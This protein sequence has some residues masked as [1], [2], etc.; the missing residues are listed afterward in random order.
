MSY[1]S[2]QHINNTEKLR[3]KIFFFGPNKCKKTEGP[4]KQQF[5]NIEYALSSVRASYMSYI[6]MVNRPNN[7]LP[8]NKQF[9]LFKQVKPQIL[10]FLSSD[11]ECV[12]LKPLLKELAFIH[13]VAS[14]N[15]NLM[16]LNITNFNK[17]NVYFQ[18]D[19]VHN[20]FI[21]LQVRRKPFSSP[22]LYEINLFFLKRLKILL[23]DVYI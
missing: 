7:F 18:L 5:G 23:N 9:R 20:Y 15:M 22:V 2:K 16:E 6:K 19:A 17:F 13:S 8:I 11:E 21:V 10:K 4:K 12:N 1:T 3:F 14:W